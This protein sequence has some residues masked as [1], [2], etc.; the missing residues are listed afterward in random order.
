M[1]RLQIDHR[2]EYRFS[3]PVTLGLHRMML[4]PRESHSVRISSSSLE[5]TPKP[6]IRWRRDM[7]DNSVALVS[8]KERSN[9]LRIDSSSVIEHFEEAP[10]DFVV[11]DYAVQHPFAYL[12]DEDLVLAPFRAST[13]PK[14]VVAIR[15]WLASLGLGKGRMETFVLLDRMNRSIQGGLRYES[16]EE[17]GV[18]SPS[19]TLERGVGSCRDFAALFME[20]CRVLGL[21]SRFV[22]GYSHGPASEAGNGTAHAW[23][24]VYLPGP[25]WKGFDPTS[26]EL[27][28]T[29]HIAVAMAHHP[30]KVPPVAGSFTGP[31]NERP[32]L[33]VRVSV[34]ELKS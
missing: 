15:S 20:G 33:E 27:V 9:R 19:L 25:G 2:T 23:A 16:R 17:A 22:S 8:F 34:R 7:L 26:G 31:Q 1:R 32:T 18:Q 11:D 3:A 4:R 24:E 13:W 21:A 10:L 28:G 29:S 6:S 12:V 5:I 14:D 30:E